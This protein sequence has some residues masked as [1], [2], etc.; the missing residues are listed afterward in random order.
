MSLFNGRS[1]SE[2]KNLNIKLIKY[3]FRNTFSRIKTE[4]N[5]PSFNKELNKKE[6][7]ISSNTDLLAK[8]ANS[9]LSGLLITFNKDKDKEDEIRKINSKKSHKRINSAFNISKKFNFLKDYIKKSSIFNSR[10][11]FSLSGS[12]SNDRDLKF[13]KSKSVFNLKSSPSKEK[14]KGDEY[15]SKL[16]SPKIIKKKKI[17][18]KRCISQKSVKLIKEVPKIY[19]QLSRNA[20]IIKEGLI[21]NLSE[22]TSDSKNL[23]K[24]F[25]E[26]DDSKSINKNINNHIYFDLKEKIKKK[27]FQH[28]KYVKSKDSNLITLRDSTANLINF[29]DYLEDMEDNVFYI[30]RRYLLKRYPH[31]SKDAGLNIHIVN[32]KKNKNIEKIEK[33]SNIIF[34]LYNKNLEIFD[35]LNH[36]FILPKTIKYI[37]K[38]RIKK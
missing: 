18:M 31:L 15:N 2:R 36:K 9:H 30:F 3:P 8:T 5:I 27:K 11:S 16:N 13:C 7:E 1:F 25:T 17:K 6:G 23:K 26:R 20:F 21:N 33:N 24:Y 19:N 22:K 37:K 28:F 10:N 32:I 12:L 4:K 38:K 29:G 34:S 35:N 14:K